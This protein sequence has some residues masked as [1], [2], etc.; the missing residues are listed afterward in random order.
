MYLIPFPPLRA[1]KA[2]GKYS[3]GLS[4]LVGR[5]IKLE[6]TREVWKDPA[7]QL[8]TVANVFTIDRGISFAVSA[9][10]IGCLGLLTHP[11]VHRSAI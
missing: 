3:E 1:A 10:P 7:S 9:I 4:D 5:S 6:S 8:F 2:E 11:H